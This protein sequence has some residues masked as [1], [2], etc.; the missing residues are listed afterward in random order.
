MIRGMTDGIT[1]MRSQTCKDITEELNY[2]DFKTRLKA[3]LVFR[4][5]LWQNHLYPKLVHDET[6]CTGCGRCVASCPVQCLELKEDRIIIGD[7]GR[8]CIHCT[9]CIHVCPENALDFQ[10]DKDKWEALF[11]KAISGRGPLS[12]HE[13][14]KSAVYPLELSPT[15]QY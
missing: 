10:C 7:N 11:D 1:A 9:Q 2:Q 15:F 6:L 4:E 13:K 5:R 8:A 14:P 3:R 12:S